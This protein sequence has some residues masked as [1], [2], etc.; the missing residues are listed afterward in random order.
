MFLFHIFLCRP[1]SKLA[2]GSGWMLSLR[3]RN[4]AAPDGGL[5]LAALVF[6]FQRQDGAPA[7]LSFT[8][9]QHL[10]HKVGSLLSN[11]VYV[12]NITLSQVYKH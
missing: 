7:C 11:N 2:A 9:M 4:M 10:F 1:G 5:P 12:G 3:S 6:N 8:D